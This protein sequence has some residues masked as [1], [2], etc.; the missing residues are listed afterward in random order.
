MVDFISR[1]VDGVEDLDLQQVPPEDRE[2][3]QLLFGGLVEF[4]VR[5]FELFESFLVHLLGAIGEG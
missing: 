2:T 1:G 5:I 3:L 4:S